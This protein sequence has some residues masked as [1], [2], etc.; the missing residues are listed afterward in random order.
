MCLPN[1]SAGLCL[2]GRLGLDGANI[3]VDAQ[4]TWAVSEADSSSELGYLVPKL[5]VPGKRQG[6]NGLEAVEQ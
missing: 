4:V 3:S 5:C 6:E 1:E 2:T